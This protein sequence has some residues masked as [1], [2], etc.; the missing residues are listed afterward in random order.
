MGNPLQLL[1]DWMGKVQ[2]QVQGAIPLPQH[3]LVAVMVLLSGYFELYFR[4]EVRRHLPSLK[5]LK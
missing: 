1:R 5:R 4:A 2:A 3:S